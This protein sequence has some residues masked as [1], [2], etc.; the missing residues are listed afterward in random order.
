MKTEKLDRN[1]LC[2]DT[3]VSKKVLNNRYYE[4]FGEFKRACQSFFRKKKY[5]PELQNLLMENFHIRT[6]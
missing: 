4:T 6:V 1:E 5:L 2:N 3:T